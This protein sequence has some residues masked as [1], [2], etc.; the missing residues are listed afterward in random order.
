MEGVNLKSESILVC[1]AAPCAYA[2]VCC[3]LRVAASGV[4]GERYAGAA[5]GQGWG[6]GWGLGVSARLPDMEDVGAG[7][8]MLFSRVGTRWG[9][10][11]DARVPA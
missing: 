3:V 6:W 9:G 7:R 1:C 4:V 5:G 2:A 11:A 8:E 10:I